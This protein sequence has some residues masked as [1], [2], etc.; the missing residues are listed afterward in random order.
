MKSREVKQ[1][2]S[3]P[4]MSRV[5]VFNLVE[6]DNYW[7]VGEGVG[8]R[9]MSQLVSWS[10]D[11]LCEILRANGKLPLEVGSVSEAHNYLLKRGL[12]QPSMKKRSFEKIGAAIRFENLREEGVEPS[13]LVKHQYG[14]LHNKN[15]VQPLDVVGVSDLVSRATEIFN[16]INPDRPMTLFDE[17]K[18]VIKE[19]MTEEELE[20]KMRELESDSDREMK[21]LDEFLRN[22]SGEEE[23]K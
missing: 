12:Y 17:E 7:E 11:L 22:S 23:E 3:V 9:T 2:S 21:A 15:S 19:K 8:V 4:V 13:K 5:S 10:L 14:I 20:K 18:V 6:L 16:N 1:E